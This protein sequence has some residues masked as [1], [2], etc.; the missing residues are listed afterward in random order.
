MKKKKLCIF[1]YKKN[2]VIKNIWFFFLIFGKW[3][4]NEKNA[5]QICINFYPTRIVTIVLSVLNKKKNSNVYKQ[6]KMSKNLN[7][8]NV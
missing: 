2:I 7:Y 6:L 4:I 1:N 8:Q 3:T 5:Y